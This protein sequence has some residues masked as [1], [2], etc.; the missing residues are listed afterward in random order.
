MLQI[1]PLFLEDGRVFDIESGAENSS[2]VCASSISFPD[3]VNL[4]GIA[5]S[6]SN[7]KKNNFL[8]N[9]DWDFSSENLRDKVLEL[10]F[11]NNKLSVEDILN[12]FKSKKELL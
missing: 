5:E 9:Y 7:E 3:E 10:I 12:D 2:G 4:L 11:P 8:N 6:I 1:Q